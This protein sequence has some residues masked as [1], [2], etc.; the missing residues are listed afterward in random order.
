MAVRWLARREFSR[1]ELAQRLRQRGVTIEDAER[2]LDDLAAAGYLSDARFAHALVAQK[3]GR[4]GK[5]AIVHA[6]KE[7]GISV[8]EAAVALAQVAGADE[9]ADARVL[10]Q[11]RFGVPPV[12][13]REK[14]RQVR[15]LLARG[16]SVSIALR[17][18]RAAG[19]RIDD[20]L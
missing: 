9:F 15:F 5:R 11:Q 16:Y 4:Y 17:I 1:A 6:L 10:W 3:A 7:R 8:D 14:A 19:T 13:D 18:L 20:D 12:N 2:A